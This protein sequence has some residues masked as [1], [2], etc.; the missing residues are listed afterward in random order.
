MDCDAFGTA[1][2]SGCHKSLRLCG[3]RST[4][5]LGH[6]GVEEVQIGLTRKAIDATVDASG[7]RAPRVAIEEVR[8]EKT[9]LFLGHD[10][11]TNGPP[12]ML[13]REAGQPLCLRALAQAPRRFRRVEVDVA[14]LL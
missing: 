2:V 10:A 6:R 13:E 4:R 14:A 3:G 9:D 5:Q 11:R 12:E 7:H 1:S 8:H